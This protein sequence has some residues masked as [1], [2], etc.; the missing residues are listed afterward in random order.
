MKFEERKEMIL[1]LRAPMQ[2]GKKLSFSKIAEIVGCRRGAV[3]GILYRDAHP[4]YD[5]FERWRRAKLKKG[6]KR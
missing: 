4:E 6:K 5:N 3:A 1:K 2:S